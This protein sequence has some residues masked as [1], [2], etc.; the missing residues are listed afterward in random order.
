[1]VPL[2]DPYYV[3]L[4]HLQ[5]YACYLEAIRIDP[6][7]AI[8]WSNLAGLFMEVGD[9]NK[10]MQYYKVNATMVQAFGRI[11]KYLLCIQKLLPEFYILFNVCEPNRCILVPCE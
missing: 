2:N 9:L 5:A 3:I 7:F 8:A 6:H 11:E 1:M 10:A 4:L